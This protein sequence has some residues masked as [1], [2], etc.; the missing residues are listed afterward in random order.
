MHQ[1]S[2]LITY[3]VVVEHQVYCLR[4]SNKA[5]GWLPLVIASLQLWEGWLMLL[6][7][8]LGHPSLHLQ[9]MLINLPSTPGPSNASLTVCLL[10][11]CNG[12]LNACFRIP[13]NICWLQIILNASEERSI[14]KSDFAGSFS[15]THKFAFLPNSFCQGPNGYIG[16]VDNRQICNLMI[17]HSAWQALPIH[18]KWLKPFLTGNFV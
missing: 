1:K 3:I 9:K 5:L 13:V 4:E 6:E 11:I 17:F 2:L 16:L 14:N 12:S 18:K 8:H 10:A 15:F 7:G